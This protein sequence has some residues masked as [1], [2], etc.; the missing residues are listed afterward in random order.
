MR[1]T[2]QLPIQSIPTSIGLDDMNETSFDLAKR[3]RTA[4]QD[5]EIMF[6]NSFQLN[7]GL[8]GEP[9]NS[10]SS[11]QPVSIQWQSTMPKEPVNTYDL[12]LYYFNY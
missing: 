6:D 11:I 4:S 3:R 10:Y 9:A 12:L 7:L 5:G 2:S 8:G 1:N